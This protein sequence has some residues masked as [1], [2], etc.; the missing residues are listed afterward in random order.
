MN[1]ETADDTAPSCEV[2]I[3]SSGTNM[4]IAMKLL[5][6]QQIHEQLVLTG[7][8]KEGELVVEVSGDQLEIKST[9]DRTVREIMQAAFPDEFGGLTLKHGKKYKTLNDVLSPPANR[10]ERR[11][12]KGRGKNRG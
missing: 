5:Y 2:L 6:E 12:A 11:A 4:D 1:K 3:T 8:A 7:F 9:S 10:A